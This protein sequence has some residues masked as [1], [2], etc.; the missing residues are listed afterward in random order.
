MARNKTSEPDPDLPMTPPVSDQDGWEEHGLARSLADGETVHG[1]YLG[2]ETAE[3]PNGP[4]KR[5]HFSTPAGRVVI[6][7]AALLDSLLA[8]FRLGRETQ[9]V[10]TGNK[11]GKAFE[12]IVRQRGAVMLDETQTIGRS[13]DVTG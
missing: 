10:R 13:I 7:G 12:Y 4:C 2:F 8:G 1:F 6:L 3:L 5:H 11:I 9:V